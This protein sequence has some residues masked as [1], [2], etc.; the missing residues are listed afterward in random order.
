MGLSH[1][2]PEESVV[3]TRRSEGKNKKAIKASVKGK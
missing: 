2:S 1:Q 3:N